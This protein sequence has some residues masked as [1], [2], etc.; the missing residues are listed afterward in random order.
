[1]PG[2]AAGAV[3]AAETTVPARTRGR[4][5]THGRFRR[6]RVILRRR[7]QLDDVMVVGESVPIDRGE[8]DRLL[9]QRD[10]VTVVRLRNAFLEIADR[11]RRRRARA[12]LQP[13]ARRVR[14]LVGV[15]PIRAA[16][17]LL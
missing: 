14:E 3:V 4:S 11:R 5:R 15:F 2:S 8:I 13:Y 9:L 17:L 7:P 6:R 10:I 12:P 16:H 1:M